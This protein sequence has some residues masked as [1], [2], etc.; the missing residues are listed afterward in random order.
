[1]AERV[2]LSRSTLDKRFKKSIGRT[3]D[4]EIRRVRLERAKELLARSQLAIREVAREAGYANEQYLSLMLRRAAH[5]TPSQYRR[6]H[7]AAGP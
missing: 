4:E 5:C 3:A 2:Q 6:Q 1:V 7:R